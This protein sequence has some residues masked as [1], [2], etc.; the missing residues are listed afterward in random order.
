[1]NPA[2]EIVSALLVLNFGPH[3]WGRAILRLPGYI[4]VVVCPK[5]T[6]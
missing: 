4:G 5:E 6:L 1:M 2:S 3:H